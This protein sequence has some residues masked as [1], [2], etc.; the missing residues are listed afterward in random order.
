PWHRVA[1]RFFSG[2]QKTKRIDQQ[3][4]LGIPRLRRRAR[5]EIIQQIR[6][7]AVLDPERLPTLTAVEKIDCA[8]DGGADGRIDRA[9][10]I[11]CRRQKIAIRAPVVS[12]KRADV[13]K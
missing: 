10:A 7:T 6:K 2:E 1:K 8:R 13:R 5:N 3:L 9:I 4:D 12:Q 11:E